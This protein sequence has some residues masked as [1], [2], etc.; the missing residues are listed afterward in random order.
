MDMNNRTYITAIYDGITLIQIL[1]M[2]EDNDIIV[3]KKI[4]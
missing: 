3:L 2:I 1:N 4:Q